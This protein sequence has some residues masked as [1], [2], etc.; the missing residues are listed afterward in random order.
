M[1][2]FLWRQF[3]PSTL[4][5]APIALWICT[6]L[7][8]YIVE[9]LQQKKKKKKKKT[10][11]IKQKWNHVVISRVTILSFHPVQSQPTGL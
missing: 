2:S 6:Q 5:K 10:V 3:Y 11:F 7:A 4:E 9:S 1:S 8:N